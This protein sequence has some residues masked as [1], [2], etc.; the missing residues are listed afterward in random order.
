MLSPCVQH[1]ISD[2]I[3][4]HISEKWPHARKWAYGFSE[5]AYYGCKSALK[6]LV[7]LG[8]LVVFKPL[9]QP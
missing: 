7:I 5:E 2:N 4:S 6:S 9:L 8:I 3:F 1:L